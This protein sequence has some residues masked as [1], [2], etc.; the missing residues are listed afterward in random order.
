MSAPFQG[1]F[2]PLITPI[3]PAERP[4]LDALRRLVAFQL[5]NGVSGLWA[6]GTTSEFAAFDEDER[7][8]ILRT[9]VDTAAG[10]VPVIANVS[11]ASTRLT[12]RHARRAADLGADAVAAT[13]P[14]YYPHSQDE[15]LAHYRAIRAAVDLPVFIYNIPQTVRVRLELSTARTLAAEGTVAGIKDSQNDL[16]WFRQLTLATRGTDFAPLAG[17]RYLIDAAVLAGAVGA[18][19]S[20]GN[21]FPELCVAAYQT[22]ASGDFERA[23]SV[24]EEIARIEAIVG[25]ITSG[26]RNAAMLGFIKTVLA[27]R[28]II[29]DASVTSP[30]RTLRDDERTE[31]LRRLDA[32][33]PKYALS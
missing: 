33:R 5:E 18:V 4:D 9:V 27:D 32:I 10:R 16:E 23:A 3:N 11:D 20:L 22:A 28:G 2:I 15:L 13:P 31:M 6:L 7:G 24:S 25:T 21:A 19:P 17:T 26:S 29:T 8:A 1:I 14:Y 12:I 30:L